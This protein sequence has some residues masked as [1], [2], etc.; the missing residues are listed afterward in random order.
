MNCNL[1]GAPVENG[2]CTY[3]GAVVSTP[4]AA[5]GP[6]Y[7]GVDQAGQQN[8]QPD[9]Q[10]QGSQQQGYQQQFGQQQN[11]TQMNPMQNTALKS[12]KSKT[13]TLILA[14]FLGWIGVHRYYVGKVGTGLLYTFTI[15]IFYVGW[16]VDIV[17]I[18]SNT[19]QDSEGRTIR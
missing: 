8:Q 14:I 15:G 11:Y 19:F 18:A 9:Y 1:C 7:Q 13:T 5:A 6:Q 2:V 17:K 3:C 4:Q 12:P 10:Q 16:I